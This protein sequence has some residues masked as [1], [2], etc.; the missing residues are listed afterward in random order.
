MAAPV[1][2]EMIIASP[3]AAACRRCN[4]S[5]RVQR[6]KHAQSL[7]P[8]FHNREVRIRANPQEEF[9]QELAEYSANRDATELG[10]LDHALE[11]MRKKG[12]PAG[13]SQE[14]FDQSL[15][16]YAQYLKD[17]EARKQM[18]AT[19]DAAKNPEVQA[20]MEQMRAVMGN[21][22]LMS[23]MAELK[24]DPEMKGFFEEIQQNGMAALSK[25]M[26]DQDFLMKLSSKLGDIEMPE[27]TVQSA[28]KQSPPAGAAAPDITNLLQAAKYGDVEAA[29]DF[30]AIGHDVNAADGEKRTSL[31]YA[32]A[33]NH[34]EILQALLNAGANLEL[35]DSKDNTPLHYA[36]GY[37]RGDS[38]TRL[39]KAGANGKALNESKHTPLQ[40]V[41]MEP[42]NPLN[43]EAEPLMALKAAAGE[44]D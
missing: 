28:T 23:R 1:L 3:A 21:E 39:V 16:T 17:P 37:A 31:H 13:M 11:S 35:A 24:G 6:R 25:Y 34:F 27:T 14:E 30:I 40:L 18:Q 44:T 4:A 43:N 12:P 19:A 9:Q 32:V 5:A 36:A 41:T 2:S 22:Q 8:P 10:D 15:T 29:E 42:R 38:V 20:Q 33:Y 26:A 7:R